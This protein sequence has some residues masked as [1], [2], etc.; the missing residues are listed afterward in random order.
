MRRDDLLLILERIFD[1][2]EA[3]R[4]EL[5]EQTKFAPSYVSALV[6][7]LRR[8]GLVEEGDRSPSRAGRRRVLLHIT[9]DL[10]HF[11]GI[12]IGRANTRIVVTDFLGRTLSVKRVE[13]E[14]SRGERHVLDLIDREISAAI[15][16]DGVVKG[17]GIAMSGV[18]DHNSGTVLF[19]PK[20]AGWND[21]PLRKMIE[22]KHKLPVVLE[23][24]VR[25]MALA[26]AKF[27]GGNGRKDFVY[28][29]VSM[30][31]GAAIFIDNRLYLGAKDLAGEFGHTTIDQHGELCSCGNR[32]CLEVY[33]SGSAILKAV[34][35]GLQHGVH[36]SLAPANPGEVNNRVSIEAIVQAAR[37]G[38][39][40]ARTVL[41]EAGLH[42]GTGIASIVNLLNPETIVLGG[43]VPRAAKNYLLRPLLH[44]F[45]ARAFHRSVQD[46]KISISRLGGEAGAIGAAVQ[47]ASKLLPTFVK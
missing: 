40:F 17:I 19:W 36:S 43:E 13:T 8:R 4:T 30:G 46:F 20:V 10:G 28:I 31:I 18:I 3:S 42:L 24:S 41:W 2:S 6:S 21:I 1:Q 47:I 15:E 14:T 35:D 45:R 44:S 26:E 23:D 12:R 11:V 39:Q 25:T 33:A 29:V 22:A 32:G 9:P 27:G 16:N 34:N 5:A 37:T 7:E 38:D